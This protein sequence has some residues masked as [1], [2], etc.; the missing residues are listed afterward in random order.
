MV[1]LRLGPAEVMLTQTKLT[2]FIL[3]GS[4][5]SELFSLEVQYRS[6][7]IDPVS[8]QEET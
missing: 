3:A 4:I 8:L 2:I 1:R 7:F 5:S 6:S